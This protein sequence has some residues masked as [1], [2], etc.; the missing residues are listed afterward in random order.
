M[1]I[2]KC[3]LQNISISR[4]LKCTIND[5]NIGNIVRE[6]IINEYEEEKSNKEHKMNKKEIKRGNTILFYNI[7]TLEIQ[8]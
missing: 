3:R 1:Q 2:K 8:I 7:V 6:K 5:N 4:I